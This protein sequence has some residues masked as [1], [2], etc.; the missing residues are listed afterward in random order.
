MAACP[1]VS[2]KSVHPQLTLRSSAHERVT[3]QARN[4]VDDEHA[5]VGVISGAGQLVEKVRF[6]LKHTGNRQAVEHRILPSN[7]VTVRGS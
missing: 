6:E 1:D 3:E 7:F 5:G 2:S 4:V